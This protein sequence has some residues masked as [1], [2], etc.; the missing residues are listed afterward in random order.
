MTPPSDSPVDEGIV[1]SRCL[2]KSQF[3]NNSFSTQFD[4]SYANNQHVNHA[5]VRNFENFI[6]SSVSSPQFPVQSSMPNLQSSGF[7]VG[8]LPPFNTF[9]RFNSRQGDYLSQSV[10]S[11]RN[12]NSL[13]YNA[14][15]AMMYGQHSNYNFANTNSNNFGFSHSLPYGNRMP[16]YGNMSNSGQFSTF[17]NPQMA[18]ASP[19]SYSNTL[20]QGNLPSYGFNTS[21]NYCNVSGNVDGTQNYVPGR[22]ASH[23]VGW[24]TAQTHNFTPTS[25]QPTTLSQNADAPTFR[26]F[27]DNPSQMSVGST[28]GTD[29]NITVESNDV[30]KDISTSVPIPKVFTLHDE[31]AKVNRKKNADGSVTVTLQSEQ[32]GCSLNANLLPNPSSSG[33]ILS[34]KSISDDD[35]LDETLTE[36]PVV[37]SNIDDDSATLSPDENSNSSMKLLP[38]CVTAPN[39]IHNAATSASVNSQMT[40]EM[41]FV[42]KQ[43]KTC[44]NS[45]QNL[46]RKSIQSIIDKVIVHEF[47][48]DDSNDDAHAEA[49][50]SVK[51]VKAK[52]SDDGIFKLPLSPPLTSTLLA[53]SKPTSVAFPMQHGSPCHEMS[54]PSADEDDIFNSF[55]EEQR[56]YEGFCQTVVLENQTGFVD[57]IKSEPVDIIVVDDSDEAE[58][59]E[60]ASARLRRALTSAELT[61]QNDASTVPADFM[62]QLSH[63]Y[64]ERRDLYNRV[65]EIPMVDS[66]GAEVS[67]EDIMSGPNDDAPLMMNVP[68]M[69][70]AATAMAA[71]DITANDTRTGEKHNANS[72]NVQYVHQ[73]DSEQFSQK[74]F[75]NC[76]AQYVQQSDATSSRGQSVPQGNSAKS[77]AQY[78]YEI[79]ID[80]YKPQNFQNTQRV[81]S[82][83][84]YVEQSPTTTCNAE[85][86]QSDVS[87][88]STVQMQRV[89]DRNI[90]EILSEHNTPRWTRS[91][92]RDC[93]TTI[94]YSS[95]SPVRQPGFPN[96][97]STSGQ[98][99]PIIDG[100]LTFAPPECNA[101][102]TAPKISSTMPTKFAAASKRSASQSLDYWFQEYK[103]MQAQKWKDARARENQ[104]QM[105]EAF[106]A[107]REAQLEFQ[108]VKRKQQV[109]LCTVGNL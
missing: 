74:H 107:I 25:N 46:Q 61:L 40:Q 51:V 102:S 6:P 32:S 62:D 52:S 49:H 60:E 83:A 27:I 92:P 28:S 104:A 56:H 76:N 48:T 79:D 57:G 105:D 18:S 38:V 10:N 23:D 33:D 99:F 16:S 42:D 64:E 66:S 55:K 70:A 87:S 39:Q 77:N 47:T 21:Q 54:P 37:L 63:T 69:N 67:T 35:N 95:K 31:N 109:R 90:F 14:P 29:A 50:K 2:P 24:Q 53:K 71:N 17:A 36:N 89:R 82:K 22:S 100:E 5:N 1:K 34:D 30:T 78:V 26:S 103:K 59:L 19:F 86:V 8:T 68:K 12:P 7:N 88:N 98:K 58:G 15:S 44:S 91:R 75:A 4:N 9:S 72:Q 94:L 20:G 101:L 85:H 65:A 3:L 84:Q 45:N 13:L 97:S 96:L 73:S 108:E 106:T 80:N 41:S 43:S 81:H 11:N 93:M